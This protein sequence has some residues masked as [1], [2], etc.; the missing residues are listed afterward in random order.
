MDS[1]SGPST[2]TPP[3]P[4]TDGSADGTGTRGTTMSLDDGTTTGEPP[5]TSSSSSGSSGSTGEPAGCHPLLA[6]VYYDTT[7]GAEDGEQWVKLWNACDV[8]VDLGD[9]SLGWGGVDYTIGTMDLMGT[10]SAGE[11]FIVGGPMSVNDNAFPTIDFAMNFDPDLEKSGSPGDGVALFLGMAKDIEA[12]TIPVDA[13]IYGNNN[14]SNLLDS[15]GDTPAPHVG[16]AGDGETLRRTAVTTW[17]I[18]AMPMP[19]LCPPS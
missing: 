17:I 18:E 4:T 6:E 2:G 15:N 1:T 11:C 5:P 8:D 16:D 14:T 3:G 10:I 19:D 7:S 9:Y 12:D 13:V